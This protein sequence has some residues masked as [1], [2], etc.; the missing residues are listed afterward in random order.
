MEQLAGWVAPA[1]TMIAAMMTAANLGARFTGWGF[2]V[3]LVGSIAWTT[4][5]LTSGQQNLVLSN[6]FLTLVNIVGIWRW[7]GRQAKYV[8]GSQVAAKKSARSPR[9]PTL[10]SAA[11]LLGAKVTG[12][13]GDAIGTVVD[14]MAR[15]SGTEL[16]YVVVSEGGMAGVGERLHAVDPRRLR[17]TPDGV[18]TDLTDE[19]LAALPVIETEAWPAELPRAA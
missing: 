12:P 2:V 6:A 4:V 14:T 7:L 16:A 13:N 8:D 9:V 5:G 19:Q 18:E 17:F 1:A 11:S 3:F 10:F 15:C